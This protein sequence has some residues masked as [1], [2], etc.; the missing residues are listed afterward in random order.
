MHPPPLPVFYDGSRA[1]TANQDEGTVTVVNL[2]SHTVEKTL[3]VVGNPRT[4]VSTQ[5]S[6][7]GKV[8]VSS[9][10]SEFLT[11][12]S[13]TSD[14]VDTTVLLEGN[15]LDVRTT[16]Q[17]GSGGNSNN[18][19]RRAGYGQPCYRPDTTA[20]KYSASLSDCRYMP[21]P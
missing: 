3:S 6:L 4:V 20:K 13:T 2:T 9:P 18:L 5:N 17:S 15:I 16:T 1:Y 8:Y 11:I 19:S 21:Q 10:N 12:I 7:F 14:L